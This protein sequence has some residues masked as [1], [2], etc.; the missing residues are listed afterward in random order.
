M[1]RVYHQIFARYF[2]NTG[3]IASRIETSNSTLFYVKAALTIFYMLPANLDSNPGC[4]YVSVRLYNNLTL[5]RISEP[6]IRLLQCI[7][8][9][10]YDVHPPAEVVLITP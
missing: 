9:K 4:I 5:I 2:Y 3:R 6:K 8:G 1:I 10:K 7:N